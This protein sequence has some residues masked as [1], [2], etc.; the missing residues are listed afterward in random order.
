ML[1]GIGTDIVDISRLQ[2]TIER[3][4]DSFLAHTYTRAELDACPAAGQ[5][6]FEFLAGR[7]A[8]KEACSK[9]LGTGITAACALKEI[10]VLNNSLGQPEITLAGQAEKTALAKGM[11]AV[12]VTISHEKQYACATVVIESG[13]NNPAAAAAGSL[14]PLASLVGARVKAAGLHLGTAESCTGGL[15]AGTLTAIPG[16]SEWFDGGVITYTNEWKIRQLGVRPETLE[17][18]GAVSEETVREM[19]LGLRDR[20]GLTA[21]LAVSGVAGPG[22]GS[23][24]KPVGTVCLGALAG[25]RLEVRRCWF[26]GDRQAV[27]LQSVRTCLELLDAIL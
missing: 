11:T 3:T 14:L 22:G 20:L 25:D 23:P 5:R 2:A 4:G 10:T 6:R 17:A 27:R 15:I 26:A 9:A 12:Q 19:L 7:W 1:L 18:H 8:A 21:G 24:A 13:D 16:S